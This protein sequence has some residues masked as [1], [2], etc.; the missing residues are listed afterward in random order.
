MIKQNGM[1]AIHSDGHHFNL[2]VIGFGYFV[3]NISNNVRVIS[4]LL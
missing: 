1:F 3:S 2:E 4:M